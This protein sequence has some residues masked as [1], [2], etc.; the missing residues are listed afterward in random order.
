MGTSWGLERGSSSRKPLN[1]SRLYNSGG[2][3]HAAAYTGN[4]TGSL[5]SR[6]SHEAI[7]VTRDLTVD[8]EEGRM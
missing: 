1:F 5:P 7:K 3:S 2:E 4:S 8:T 6:G